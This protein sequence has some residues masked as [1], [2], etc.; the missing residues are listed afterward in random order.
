MTTRT[1]LLMGL[2]GAL[3]SLTAPTGSAQ[4][5]FTCEAVARRGDTDPVGDVFTNR[6]DDRVAVNASGDTLFIGRAG[7]NPQTLYRYTAGG[8]GE[9][10]ASMGDPAPGGSTF[11][12]FCSRSFGHLAINFQ[13]D[14]AFLAKLALPGEG[15]FVRVGD[16]LVKAAQ[17][18]DLASPAGEPFV[19]FPSVSTIRD[20]GE[21]YFV[22]VL[23]GGSSSIFRY[24][25]AADVRDTLLDTTATDD[26]GHPFCMF[27]TVGLSDGLVAFTATVGMPDC[28]TPVQGVFR[29][30][31]PGIS[32]TI[33]RAGDPSPIG[34][35]TFE[36]FL[37]TPETGASTITFAARVT[38]LPFTGD[39]IFRWDGVATTTVAGVGD[40]A[41]GGNGVLARLGGQHRQTLDGSVF[42]RFLTKRPTSRGLF[43]FGTISQAVLEKTEQ[44]PPW[45]TF[46]GKAF[47]K[48]LGPP[49]IDET[50]RFVAVYAQV[51]DSFQ[52]VDKNAILRCRP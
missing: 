34:G 7:A 20:S 8:S 41:P 13:G 21:V 29:L 22:G 1:A 18:T 31:D 3:L 25:S 26:A 47:Y 19:S 44:P 24:D 51:H 52:P 23:G 50:G 30:L 5:A 14:A 15:V 45:P 33:A 10:I 48:K 36:S 35:T 27:Q 2:T 17:T 42:A 38:G 12:R 46:G 11:K 37:L 4:A 28:T 32:Q 39:A 49:A 43:A 40:A 9:I 6:F 16:T